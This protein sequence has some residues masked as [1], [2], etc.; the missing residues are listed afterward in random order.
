MGKSGWE[1]LLRT[2][3]P[4]IYQDPFGDGSS[5]YHKTADGLSIEWTVPSPENPRS[6]KGYLY[7]DQTLNH[8]MFYHEANRD[9]LLDEDAPRSTPGPV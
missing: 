2:Q 8:A 9:Y 5:Y 4:G 6:P 1:A 3:S 7:W